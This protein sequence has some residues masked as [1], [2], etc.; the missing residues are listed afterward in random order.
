M[1][2]NFDNFLLSNCSGENFGQ[3]DENAWNEKNDEIEADKPTKENK[4][5]GDDRAEMRFHLL[6]SSSRTVTFLQ[7][8]T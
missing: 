3:D 4:I 5:G 1:L 8:T 2:R 7:T 6:N